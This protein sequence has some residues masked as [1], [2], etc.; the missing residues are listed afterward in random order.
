MTKIAIDTS[1]LAVSRSHTPILVILLERYFCW[2]KYMFHNDH[3]FYVCVIRMKIDKK[4][5][6]MIRKLLCKGN[7]HFTLSAIFLSY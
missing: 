1:C 6:K 5:I 4:L 2:D 3:N 7:L